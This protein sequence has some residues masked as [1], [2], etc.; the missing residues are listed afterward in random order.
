MKSNATTHGEF[1]LER[2]SEMSSM[3]F[4]DSQM[5]RSSGIETKST[6][7]PTPVANDY[8]LGLLKRKVRQNFA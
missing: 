2:T 3:N 4:L 6:A 5:R 8:S 7:T 1:V